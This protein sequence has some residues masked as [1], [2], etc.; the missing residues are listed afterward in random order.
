MN[1]KLHRVL[2]FISV[3]L[4]CSVLAKPLTDLPDLTDTFVPLGDERP[5]LRHYVFKRSPLVEEIMGPLS[6]NVRQVSE[7]A[8]SFDVYK[9]MRVLLT[10]LRIHIGRSP[11]VEI[12]QF[13]N[14]DKTININQLFYTKPKTIWEVRRVLFAARSL[15]LRVR[16]TGAGH[17]RSPLYVDEGNIM[18]DV[19]DLQRHDG[20]FMQLN[21]KTQERNFPTIT[22]MTGVYEIELNEFMKKN[23]VTVLAQP[24]NDQETLGGM[25]A[26]STH[27]STYDEPTWSGVVVEMRLLDSMG[28]FRKFTLEKHPLI[29]KAAICNLGMF[30]IMYDITFKVYPM[31]T[32]KVVNS[33]VPL[34]DLIQNKAALKAQISQNFMNEIS[35]FPFNQLTQE[36]EDYYKATGKA[37][38]TWN[39]GNDLLWVRTINPVNESELI[40]KNLTGTLYLPSNGSL[41]GGTETGLLKARGSINLARQV[42]A[43]SYQ[44]L[45]DAFPIILP[46]RWGVETSA[47]FMVNIDNDFDRP[48][49]ALNY[50]VD[51]AEK[52]IKEN[53]S[54]PINA[55][56][57]RWFK[58]HNCFL[59]PGNEDITQPDDSGKTLVIDFLAPPAQY[60]FYPAAASFVNQFKGEKLRPHWGKR[61]DNINGIIN[62]IKNVY[63][64][65]LT[66]FKTQKRLADIDPC[67][68][69]M[70]SYLLAIFGRS[71]NCRTI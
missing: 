9:R 59:C 38:S 22:A 6:R 8:R 45:V 54:T 60:G 13:H 19:R 58:N 51:M 43:V 17:S 29:M 57:P 32:V 37:P 14:W 48:F 1:Y 35:W 47:A 30:G 34:K 71:E 4:A 55:L 24:L 3:T 39:A 33:F 2:A 44:R 27:G 61:H 49:R 10:L 42:P 56:L 21:P 25:V 70:N 36:E 23:N 28:R 31:I 41:A 50:L 5:T 26:A 20:P 52:Q 63:G 69:F 16:A 18:M 53:A 15:G 12:F 46:P 66:G 40:G 64:N 11:S 67:D 62:I 65:L 7:S 68:M